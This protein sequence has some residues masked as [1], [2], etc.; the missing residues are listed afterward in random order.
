[1]GHPQ[2]VGIH[3]AFYVN[4]LLKGIYNL[5]EKADRIFMSQV[6]LSIDRLL[7]PLLLLL[8]A[9]TFAHSPCPPILLVLVFL[10]SLSF[11]CSL[12][13]SPSPS[14]TAFSSPPSS[15]SC[16]LAFSLKAPPGTCFTSD[17]LVLR[18]SFSYSPFIFSFILLFT[19]IFDPYRKVAS[20]S[21]MRWSHLFRRTTLLPT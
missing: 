4:G 20:I 10:I 19:F 8:L 15:I 5:V 1:M 14:S 11:S 21:I 12:S 7:I 18:S 9:F 3:A 2:H 16:R 13:H 17:P 6:T